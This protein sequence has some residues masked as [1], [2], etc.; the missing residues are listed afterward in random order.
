MK[1]N[2]QT[3]TEVI[4]V[5]GEPLEALTSSVYHS[6]DTS[7]E[8]PA[9]LSGS[10]GG[11]A[12]VPPLPATFVFNRAGRRTF[13]SSDLEALREGLPAAVDHVAAPAAHH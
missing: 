6:W 12:G 11:S 9:G 10:F 8:P 3:E 1:K 5:P 13:G 4:R 2:S 7:V